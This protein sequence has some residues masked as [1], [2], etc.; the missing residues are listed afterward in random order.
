MWRK[1]WESTKKRNSNDG[2]GK[3]ADSLVECDRKRLEVRE[4]GK[5]RT[6]GDCRM[7]C[8]MVLRV[9]RSSERDQS[10]S[11]QRQTV[12]ERNLRGWE[13]KETWPKS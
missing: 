8:M 1:V 12:L 10:R 6:K 4:E 3:S 13:N 2:I 9:Q 7:Y 11:S 5:A